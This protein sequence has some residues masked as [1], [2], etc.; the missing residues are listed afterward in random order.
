MISKPTLS[1]T[2]TMLMLLLG[3]CF[4][5]FSE[6]KLATEPPERFTYEARLSALRD[7]M[8]ATPHLISAI[9]G[10][11]E[12]APRVIYV[13]GT[14]GESG[15]FS[16]YITNPLEGF[17][18]IAIDRPGFGQTRPAG[19][20]VSFEQQ[21]AAIEPLLVER[22]GRWPILVGHSLGGPIVARAAADFPDRVGGLVILA[23]SL[24]PALEDPR[25]F[26]HAAEWGLVRLI[27]GRILRTSN[28]EIMGAEEQTT[29]LA[30]CLGRVRA[31][32]RI[33][34]GTADELV[35]IGNVEYMRSAFEDVDRLHIRV[36][37]GEGHF[38]PW[39]REDEV[40]E[41]IRGLADEI[42]RTE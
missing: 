23:G 18:S 24:D 7:G 8:P 15:G 6:S 1:G 19:S 31:P 40:R 12:D 22:E 25:W 34:H 37:E 3:G 20:V 2:L 5:G 11:V 35:P 16:R 27:M 38:L 13:H 17:E 9:R 26:N 29:M 42:V 30:E 33:L 4:P 28:D 39:R 36:I 14:P 41:A 32:I 21:A 10:G